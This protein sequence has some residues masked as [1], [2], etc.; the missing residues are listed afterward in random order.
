MNAR[1][2]IWLTSALLL[3]LTSCANGSETKL[4]ELRAVQPA[5]PAVRADEATYQGAVSAIGRRDYASALDL[6]QAAAARDPQD[7]RVPNALGVVYDKLGRFDV[8]ERYYA[9]ALALAPASQIVTQNLAY[10]NYLQGKAAPT[11]MAAASPPIAAPVVVA[12]QDLVSASLP[13]PVVAA[14]APRS[15]PIRSV[16]VSAPVQP[17]PAEPV[18]VAAVTPVAPAPRAP[19]SAPSS[20]PEALTRVAAIVS[21]AYTPA[22]PAKSTA[23]AA[24]VQAVMTAAAQPSPKKPPMKVAA[25]VSATPAKATPSASSPAP[26]KTAPVRMAAMSQPMQAMKVAAIVPAA[27]ITAAPTK[28]PPVKAREAVKPKPVQAPA[29]AA[30]PQAK[31]AKPVAPAPAS[32]T[33]FV[34]NTRKPAPIKV[35]AVVRSTKVVSV[36]AKAL[37]PI[38][39]QKAR[40]PVLIGRPLRVVNASGVRGGAEATRIQLAQRGWSAPAGVVRPGRLQSRTVIRYALQ[41]ATVAKALARTIPYQVR[42]ESC[43]GCNGV[44]LIV[45]TDAL[46]WKNRRMA[47]NAKTR[48]NA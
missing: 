32:P 23:K 28:A 14:S 33:V 6:L 8:S 39:L 34:Q 19:M 40:S 18:R 2:R 17:A 20:L 12:Q 29:P 43:A 7:P 15:E 44:S 30:A 31:A 3:G 45:G 35:A 26:A 24:P 11:A 13:A 42:L 9:K 4:V 38:R 27:P 25:I 46:R 22:A 36:S 37:T 5:S 48:R 16:P 1:K 21:A 41:N 47:S 10:S